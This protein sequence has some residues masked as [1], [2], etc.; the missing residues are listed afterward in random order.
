LAW[1]A[2]AISIPVRAQQTPSPD[3]SGAAQPAAQAQT[4]PPSGAPAQQ[5]AKPQPEK[6]TDKDHPDA[7]SPASSGTTSG[8]T[9]NDRLFFALPNF[10]SLENAGNVPP[11]T[12]GQKFSVVTR[13]AFDKV[14]FGWYGFL[15][16][17]SQAENSEP[18]YGQGAQGYGK[19]Y[20][21]AFADGT[22]ENFMV[23]AVMPSLFRQDPR[24]FQLGHGGFLHR[25]G[26]AM[27]RS[28][29]TRTDSGHKQF[30]FSEIIGGMVAA[31]ISTYSYHPRSSL[32][33]RSNSAGML[34]YKF[35]P[36]DRTLTNTTKVWGTQLGYDT[37]TLVIKEFWPDIHRKISHKAK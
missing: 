16:G 31:G 3:S 30:N 7:K 19:R 12:A 26:Y 10:L 29:V 23:G 36:S 22:I 15:S 35:I 18:G 11:L 4:P 5:T 1:L 27:S 25:A 20:G 14:Q 28:F 37:L 17:L 13:S 2:L 24:F 9:S 34:T 33:V 32:Q 8:G 6:S 21:A